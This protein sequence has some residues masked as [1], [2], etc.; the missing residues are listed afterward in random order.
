MPHPYLYPQK[1]THVQ[2]LA[3]TGKLKAP[4]PNIIPPEVP[5]TKKWLGDD[6]GWGS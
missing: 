2:I 6:A 5:R 3:M 4:D 1:A